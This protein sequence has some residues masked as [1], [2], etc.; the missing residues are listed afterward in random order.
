MRDRRD[1]RGRLQHPR[2]RK[3]EPRK[4][5]TVDVDEN[6]ERDQWSKEARARL[7]E[8]R[9]IGASWNKHFF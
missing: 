7:E 4:R 1:R 6:T 3:T 9:K 2:K 8:T 5:E